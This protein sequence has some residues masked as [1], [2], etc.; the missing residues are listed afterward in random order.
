M[1]SHKHILININYRI[2]SA[3][4][5]IEE[6]GEGS[7]CLWEIASTGGRQQ[8]LVGGSKCGWDPA[9]FYDVPM[10]ESQYVLFWRMVANY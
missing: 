1:A 8:V 3:G 2:P 10:Y 5:E 4:R 9:S 7:R 6:V